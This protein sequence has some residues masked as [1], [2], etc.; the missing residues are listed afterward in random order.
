MVSYADWTTPRK[1]FVNTFFLC[2]FRP[3]QRFKYLGGDDH[4][5][6]QSH[7]LIRAWSEG[8]F[9]KTTT[10]DQGYQTI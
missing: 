1:G 2:S 6:T 7:Q 10:D 3:D 8:Y 9:K 4:E 5:Q